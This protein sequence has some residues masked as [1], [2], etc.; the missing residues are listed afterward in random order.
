MT[1]DEVASCT[2]LYEFEKKNL[3]LALNFVCDFWCFIFHMHKHT[4]YM[5]IYINLQKK[6]KIP[7]DMRGS[8]RNRNSF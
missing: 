3:M 7:L 8:I 4:I 1:L 6:K 5:Y 2:F